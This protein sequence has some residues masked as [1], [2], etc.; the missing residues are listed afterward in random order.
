M[1]L[2]ETNTGNVLGHQ[3][4]QIFERARLPIDVLE[5]I[6]NLS[7]TQQAGALRP[8][9]FVIAMHL[10]TSYKSGAMG[11]LPPLLPPG[12]YDAA[13]RF[14]RPRTSASPVPSQ[15]LGDGS[16]ASG[17]ARPFTGQSPRLSQVPLRSVS[18]G[19]S[20]LSAQVT[21]DEWAIS[22]ADK[23]QFDSI[24]ATID[25]SRRGYVS[26]DEAVTFFGNSRLPA[27]TLAQIWDLA[28]IESNGQ[29]NKDEFAVAMY[30]IRQQR[31]AR[32]GGNPLPATLPPN[33]IPPSM[34][35][36][37]RPVT[38]GLEEGPGVSQPAPPRSAAEDLFGLDALT[39]PGPLQAHSTGGSISLAQSSASILASDS[40][41]TPRQQP[42]TSS[43]FKPFTPASSWGQNMVASN[44]T[45]GSTASN[46]APSKPVQP[47]P[48]S[49]K[50]AAEDLLGDNDPEVSKKLTAETTELA[51]LSNQVGNLSQQMQE[52]KQKKSATETELSNATAQKRNFET[53]LAQLRS[54]YEQ[55]VE[56]V[57]GLE[58]RLNTCRNDNKKLMKDIAMLEGTY[59]DLQHQHRQA[60]SALEGDQKENAQLK[61]RIRTV[62][63]E[64]DKLRPQLEKLKSEA[65]QT[66]GLVAINKKQLATSEG[67]RDKL[68]E[69]IGEAT[70]AAQVLSLD[71][72]VNAASPNPE[73]VASP[74]LSPGSQSTNPFSRMSPV[75]P[76]EGA[77]SSGPGGDESP[78]AFNQH[79]TTF[80]DLFGPSYS[81]EKT[82]TPPPPT[83]FAAKSG[84]SPDAIFPVPSQSMPPSSEAGRASAVS[85]QGAL[86]SVQQSNST[87]LGQSESDFTPF[88]PNVN[89]V[90]SDVTPTISSPVPGYGPV[91]QGMFDVRLVEN[92]E[93]NNRPGISSRDVENIDTITAPTTLSPK[94]PSATNPMSPENNVRSDPT[95][96]SPSFRVPSYALNSIPGAFPSDFPTPT[97]QTSMASGFNFN[98]HA[99]EM[100]P[101]AERDFGTQPVASGR[102]DFDAAFAA[103]DTPKQSQTNGVTESGPITSMAS[104]TEG[105]KMDPGFPSLQKSSSNII[106]D[107]DPYDGKQKSDDESDQRFDDDFTPVSSRPTGIKTD[108]A[109]DDQIEMR[110]SQASELSNSSSAGP[111]PAPPNEGFEGFSG[112]DNNFFPQSMP[113]PTLAQPQGDPII[114]PNTGNRNVDS[115]NSTP[116]P[117]QS[118]PFPSSSTSP[119]SGDG[120]PQLAPLYLPSTTFAGSA[121]TPFSSSAVPATTAIPS[122]TPPAIPPPAS[123]FTLTSIPS[124]ASNFPST[125]TSAPGSAMTSPEEIQSFPPTTNLHAPPSSS[126]PLVSSS[127]SQQP[128]AQ[129]K[130]PFPPSS[131]SFTEAAQAPAP[132]AAARTKQEAFDDFDEDDFADLTDAKESD[133][134]EGNGNLDHSFV[135]TGSTGRVNGGQFRDGGV[136]G[137]R[138][139]ND[140]VDDNVGEEEDEE[141]E[142]EFDLAFDHPHSH[143]APAVSQQQSVKST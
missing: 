122:P 64:V 42:Q 1:W 11:V 51:N 41:D 8:P 22:P 119:S 12:L 55:E 39:E 43:V 16:P 4:K 14:I 63:N 44:V 46:Q 99:K 90:D 19:A 101:T 61:E 6:W 54:V 94:A 77:M 95:R 48:G 9:E 96:P 130:S 49:M 74:M 128:S 120:P 85:G 58:E 33:L 31:A 30:L 105:D 113:P 91:D 71:G 138:L 5:K 25:R 88:S 83:S 121:P 111:V 29:L 37:A 13:A 60:V 107:G 129:Q 123:S 75:I 104:P 35:R 109:M 32:D 141:E 34:R 45:G 76:S 143:Q 93:V 98:E 84:R 86:P 139:D 17:M 117:S 110:P 53:R 112:G 23:A 38:Q 56:A 59:E 27:E 134:K 50:S 20:P 3:A 140:D 125:S 28:C 80:D 66:K 92:S 114:S 78:L 40:S 21:G 2:F 115:L 118:S 81:S 47:V 108:Q 68:H 100:N 133:E 36:T 24:F 70:K 131:T 97:P 116:P 62:S 132:A 103:F 57:R 15:R 52:T 102:D 135:G 106:G 72:G 18:I 124:P 82:S 7:D 79:A 137:A 67:E 73:G 26:G 126:M 10:L 142:E 89:Q 136:K 69:E 87:S 127:V 65:R